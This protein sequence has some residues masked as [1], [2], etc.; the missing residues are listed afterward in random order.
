M[1]ILIRA[2]LDIT[3][4]EFYTKLVLRTHGC[5]GR[6]CRDKEKGSYGRRGTDSL[7]LYLTKTGH[8]AESIDGSKVSEEFSDSLSTRKLSNLAQRDF[9]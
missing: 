9:K 5:Y 2:S 1:R 7:K 6:R 4:L 3:F 8:S